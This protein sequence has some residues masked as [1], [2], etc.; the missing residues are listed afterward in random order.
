MLMLMREAAWWRR[1]LSTLPDEERPAAV[2]SQ[3]C[4]EWS[5]SSSDSGTTSCV[6]MLLTLLLCKFVCAKQDTLYTASTT[7]EK[8]NFN[9]TQSSMPSSVS[10]CI[11]KIKVACTCALSTALLSALLCCLVCARVDAGRR[12]VTN[13]ANGQQRTVAGTTCA[14]NATT[15]VDTCDQLSLLHL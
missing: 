3:Q 13:A 14:R 10:P 11:K 4:M 8:R 1:C 7:T 12:S 6:G 2:T 9:T 15:N 5:A